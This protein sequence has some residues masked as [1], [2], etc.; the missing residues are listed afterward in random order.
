M[1]RLPRLAGAL[2]GAL[3][4]TLSACGAEPEA[5]E[6]VPVV[7][8][9]AV[10]DRYVAIG[11]SFTSAPYVPNTDLAA[12]C[13]RSDANYP[14]LLAADLEITSLVDVSCSG[15]ETRDV[16]RQQSLFGEERA[17][18]QLRPLTA[19][20]DLVTVGLG[21]NDFGIFG[22]LARTCPVTGP[23]GEVVGGQGAGGQGARGFAATCGRIDPSVAD[24]LPQIEQRLVRVL[25]EVS[26]RAPDATVV[27]VG[28]P[29]FLDIDGPTCPQLPVTRE[30]ARGLDAFSA[31]L[32]DAMARAARRGGAEYADMYT[33]SAGHGVCAGEEAWVNGVNTD[34]Q[35]A[36]A[37]H[38]VSRGQAAVA[39][40]LADLLT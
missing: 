14:S 33:P 12:G 35:R 6:E 32:N 5:A 9:D 4:L 20:T 15:A 40:V 2:A 31:A 26:Q 25:R 34:T 1:R 16:R 24:R 18:P 3:A 7:S 11:D 21:G 27:L 37:L 22:Q 39:E 29:R 13:L 23:D 30:D 28:Y 38:P 19:D 10:F 36:L 17:L 8:P